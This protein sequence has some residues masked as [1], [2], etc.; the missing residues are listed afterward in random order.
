MVFT[1]FDT[2]GF[3]APLGALQTSGNSTSTLAT[4][5]STAL[6]G[7]T[8][9]V[10][11]EGQDSSILISFQ[12]NGKLEVLLNGQCVEETWQ[13][14]F[15]NP[16]WVVLGG[17]TMPAAEIAIGTRPCGGIFDPSNLYEPAPP[18]M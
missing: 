6:T 8:Y 7:R 18:L 16:Y 1:G 5:L 13:P 11:R 2:T 15:Q 14:S 12:P 10:R 9:V 4:Q 3:T 17:R